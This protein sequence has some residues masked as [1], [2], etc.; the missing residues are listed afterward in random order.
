MVVGI[1]IKVEKKSNNNYS[2]LEE[3][4]TEFELA[5]FISDIQNDSENSIFEVEKNPIDSTFEVDKNA[6]DSISD[7]ENDFVFEVENNSENVNLFE[8]LSNK[9]CLT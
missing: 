1:L 6:I 4:D 5:N 9:K 7:T 2:L 8:F 3:M